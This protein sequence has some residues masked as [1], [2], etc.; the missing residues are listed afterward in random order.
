MLSRDACTN[1]EMLAAVDAPCTVG[2][3][4]RQELVVGEIPLIQAN[5][6]LDT[7]RTFNTLL[8]GLAY[9]NG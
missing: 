7:C 2:D 8:R 6:F 3:S 1:R 9:I 4:C 5:R